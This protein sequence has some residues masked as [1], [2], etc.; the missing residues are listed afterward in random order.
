MNRSKLVLN[1]LNVPDSVS[2]GAVAS[3]LEARG[4]AGAPIDYDLST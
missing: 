4:A 2:Y 3:H 1:V